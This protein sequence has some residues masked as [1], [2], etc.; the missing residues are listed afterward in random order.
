VDFGFPNLLIQRVGAA[1][2]RR[3][4]QEAGDYTVT[5]TVVIFAMSAVAVLAG[6]GISGPL[7]GW[8]SVQASD[9]NAIRGAFLLGLCGTGLGMAA[10][11]FVGLARAL[12]QTGLISSVSVG[13][14]IAGFG[15]TL[16]GLL[17]G[18]GV[19]ALAAGLVVRSGIVF[20][21]GVVL[22]ERAYARA[23][24]RHGRLRV[25]LMREYLVVASPSALGTV[26]YGAM[27][28]AET[29]LVG[30]LISTD[31]ALVYNL[32]RRLADVVLALVNAVGYAAYG[33]FSH[34]MGS[35]DR[36]RARAVLG[37]LASLR[38]SIAVGTGALVLALNH[39]LLVLWVG[40]AYYGGPWLNAFVV[41][42]AIL[43]GQSFLLNT[44][45]RAA[46]P[47]LRGSVALSLE[48]TV[49]YGAGVSLIGWLGLEAFPAAGIASAL[50]FGGVYWNW[51]LSQLPLRQ[52]DPGSGRLRLWLVRIA[53]VAL[54]GTLGG[55]IRAPSWTALVALSVAGVIVVFGPL[56]AC[57]RA[58]ARALRVLGLGR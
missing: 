52:A 2:G 28:Q 18:W 4:L 22:A 11:A 49:R 53:V 38:L 41:F 20:A 21:A 40:E 48:A 47:V 36:P 27:G 5:G 46:G 42:Q 3:D 51:L 12:Q 44:L 25:C 54:G 9:A 37:E 26:G 57:D 29:A 7:P 24:L 10:N 8:L 50:V 13:G 23:L 16:G 39:S 32:T 56:V 14:G 15:V 31:A 45:Y 1:Y 17:G 30:L 33:G 58:L 6:I 35:S 19:W 34:L 43:V 55:I